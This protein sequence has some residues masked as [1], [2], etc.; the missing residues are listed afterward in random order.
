MEQCGGMTGALRLCEGWGRHVDGLVP[1]TEK[2]LGGLNNQFRNRTVFHQG[3]HFQAFM[4]IGGDVSGEA[5]ITI[6]NG[7]R[8]LRLRGFLRSGFASDAV[9]LAGALLLFNSDE[10]DLFHGCCNEAGEDSGQIT[11]KCR[12]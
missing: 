4:Q 6:A 11:G 3:L 7:T 2:T 9:T 10:I 12:K 8:T 1:I 5:A